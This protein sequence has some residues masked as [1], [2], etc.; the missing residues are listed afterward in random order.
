MFHKQ[1]EDERKL[2][3][4]M[5]PPRHRLRPHR[6]HGRGGRDRAIDGSVVGVI[7]KNVSRAGAVAVPLPRDGRAGCARCAACHAS[8]RRDTAFTCSAAPRPRGKRFSRGKRDSDRP[9][10]LDPRSL[11]NCQRRLERH[12][13]ATSHYYL[14]PNYTA[15]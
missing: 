14:C 6:V 10:C 13:P 3:L 12:P 4:S 1:C 15:V 7:F 8:G 11:A 2:T 9:R 5:E